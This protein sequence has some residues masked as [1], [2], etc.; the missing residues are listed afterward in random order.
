[1]EATRSPASSPNRK[2]GREAILAPAGDRPTGDADVGAP[3]RRADAPHTEGGDDGGVGH[4]PPVGGRQ[5]AFIEG[6]KADPQTYRDWAGSGEWTIE[7]T[8][9]EDDM[10]S[11]FLRKPF[12]QAIDD[13]LIPRTLA[14]IA[15]TW[16]AVHDT[17]DLTYMNLVHLTASTAPT[18]TT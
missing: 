11:P 14:T 16:G 10:F 15:G 3:R 9:K 12:Q 17:G 5:G 1:M 8:G 6:V 2:A 7:T 18:R 13:G 4:V